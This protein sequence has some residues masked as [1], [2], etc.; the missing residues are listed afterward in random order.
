LSLLDIVTDWKETSTLLLLNTGPLVD[1]L[2]ERGIDHEILSSEAELLDV[3]RDAGPL[4]LL[5]AIPTVLRLVRRI[6]QRALDADLLYANSQK[7]MILAALVGWWTGTLV[8]WHL[9]DMMTADHFSRSNRLLVPAIANL[10]LERV[11]CNSEATRA[12]FVDAGGSPALSTVIPNGIDPAPFATASSSAD[13]LRCSL[14]IPQVHPLVGVFSR[15]SSWK[16]QH[17][18]VD[19]LAELPNVH[20]I[21]VGDA[22]FD[23]DRS[24][25]ASLLQRIEEA[26]L[27][28]RVHLLG[29]QDDIPSLMKAVDVVVHTSTAPEPFGRVIVEAMMARRPVIATRAGGATEILD[30]GST[31]R[32]VPPGDAPALR[33]A[34]ADLLEDS[35]YAERLASAGHDH[36]RAE[37]SSATLLHRIR[38]LIQTTTPGQVPT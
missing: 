23:V 2:R 20:A 33:S 3:S 22:I 19:A 31:G 26:G 24:Y 4:A 9:R 15:L 30:D 13:D 32:L 34:L 16:G 29:F 21:I 38:A 12:A 35:A 36:A 1:R 37:Y 10:F 5:R 6:S 14:G 25:K 18:L 28:E 11:I 17:V 7:A 27:Q 8:V